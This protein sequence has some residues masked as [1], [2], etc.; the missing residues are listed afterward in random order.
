MSDS[1]A[2]PVHSGR[3]IPRSAQIRTLCG[4]APPRRITADDYP[5]VEVEYSFSLHG[6]WLHLHTSPD[7]PVTTSRFLT[8]GESIPLACS[9]MLGSY[10]CRQQAPPL[11]T[12]HG[13]APKPISVY[14]AADHLRD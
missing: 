7:E 14:T 10:Y 2:T 12:D 4:V 11:N 5:L 13:G 9:M 6:T 1:P 3:R 8:E